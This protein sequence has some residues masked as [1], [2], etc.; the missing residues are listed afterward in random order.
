MILG[1]VVGTV[2]STVKHPEY[3]GH[4]I[5]V[6]QPVDASGDASGD[7]FIA[8]DDVQAGVGDTVLAIREGNGARQIFKRTDFPIRAVI[9]GIVDGV[10]IPTD[11]GR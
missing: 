8:V 3:V 7:S 9:V 6:V 1:K 4:K 5:L 2:V 11:G 10:D